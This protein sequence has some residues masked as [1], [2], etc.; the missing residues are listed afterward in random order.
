MTLHRLFNLCMHAK[1]EEVR[2]KG[3]C[4]G[5]AYSGVRAG[6]VPPFVKKALEGP[7][8]AG[9]GPLSARAMEML[10]GALLPN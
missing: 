10:A 2:R 4:R 8:E 5:V 6:F 1:R 7:D 9:E 3:N